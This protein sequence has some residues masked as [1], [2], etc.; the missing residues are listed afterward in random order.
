MI[1]GNHLDFKLIL[2][3]TDPG[4][5][6]RQGTKMGTARPFVRDI[7]EWATDVKTNLSLEDSVEE[8]LSDF[9]E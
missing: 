7:Y 3:E 8:T 5:F 6:V 4:F 2:E 1:L 9:A